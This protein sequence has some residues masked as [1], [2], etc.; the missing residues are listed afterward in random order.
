MLADEQLKKIGENKYQVS[1]GND[2]GVYAEF[3]EDAILDQVK[4]NA[5]GRQVYKKVDM[6]RIMFPGDKTKE[7]VREVR[8]VAEGPQPS[9][10]ERFPRQWAAYKSQ[11]QQIQDGVPIEQWPPINKAQALELKA[12]NIHTVEQLAS[13][14]D[15]NLN[16]IGARQMRDNA[17]A[18]LDEAESGAETIA[19]RNIIEE[20]RVENIALK[21]TINGLKSISDTN[22]APTTAPKPEPSL[23]A[24]E[25]VKPIVT[26]MRK[27]PGPKPKAVDNGTNVSTIDTGYGE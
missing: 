7:I 16:W 10:I 13:V 2:Q 27:K 23:V 1:Y 3:F 20:L 12:M 9:D 25:E 26:K 11:T 15:G 22:V 18:W 17:K 14:S 8:T 21:N 6:I 5:Q 24:E 4:T 19:L